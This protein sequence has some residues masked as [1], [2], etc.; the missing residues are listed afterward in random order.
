MQFH[1]WVVV[2]VGTVLIAFSAMTRRALTM[3]KN[4]EISD[5]LS[6]YSINP[7]RLGESASVS[8]DSPP[9]NVVSL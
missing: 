1:K 4:V 8:R 9:E 7:E 5:F 3:S 2:R 6:I